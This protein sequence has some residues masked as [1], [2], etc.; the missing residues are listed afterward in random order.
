MT[1]SDARK[2]KL[3]DEYDPVNLFLERYNYD[4]LFENEESSGTTKI[5]EE[6]TDLPPMPPLEGDE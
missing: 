3:G 6:S 1:F 5:G 2:R 4:V